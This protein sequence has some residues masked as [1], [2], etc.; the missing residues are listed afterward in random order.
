M[1]VTEREP[2]STRFIRALSRGP[3][4]SPQRFE[5]P[6]VYGRE[7]I[8]R[9]ARALPPIERAYANIRFS[10]LRPKLLSVM[11]LLLPD[12]GPI[13][14]IGCGFGLFAAYFGQTQPGR[15]IVGVDPNARR[16]ELAR[17]VSE[18]VG[19]RGNEFIAG[20]ARDVGLEGPFAGAYVL[21]VMHHI[22]EQDQLP[23]LT[24]LRDL[25][26]PRGVLVVKDITTVPTFGL[27]FTRLLDRVM[28]GWDEPLR[29]RHHR[30]WGEMLASLG[31]HVRMV[32]VPDVLPY[33]HVV[34]AATKR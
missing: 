19:L 12:E 30:E 27:E 15:R 24:R 34:I 11:D 29:Y 18:S 22:P 31:F 26:A 21:D 5:A 3:R 10:I 14:D 17:R 23:M 8:S 16:I 4:P 6:E 13:L 9:I 7:A 1:P 20:D 33:P 32:R 25:L 28:V 2:V